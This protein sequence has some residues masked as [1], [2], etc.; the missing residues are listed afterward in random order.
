MRNGKRK[1]VKIFIKPVEGKE[2]CYLAYFSSGLLGSTYS[3]YF[4][5]NI[6]GAGTLKS[7]F[8]KIEKARAVLAGLFLIVRPG[9]KQDAFPR[10]DLLLVTV[11]R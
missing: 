2:G 5:D 8:P 11:S 1:E 10:D 6:M 9:G 3:V 4:H 7:I